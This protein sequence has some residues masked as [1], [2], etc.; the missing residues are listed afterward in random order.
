MKKVHFTLQG[1]GGVG[2]SYASSCTTQF[3]NENGEPVISMD[4]DPVNATLSGYPSLNAVRVELMEGSNLNQRQFD[5]MMETILEEDSNFVIDNGASS[6]IPLSNYL[7]ENSAIE[8]ISAAGKQVV[9]HTVITGGQAML[10]TLHGFTGL[11]KQMPENAQIVVWLNEFFGHIEADGK[12]FE[13]MK[14][15]QAHKDRVTGII[16]LN[17]QTSD[18][19]GKDVELMLDRKMTFADVAAGSDFGLMSKQRLAMVKR[20]IFDQLANVI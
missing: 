13:E 14:A 3:Y 9:I 10:D 7:L 19:F 20:S 18:T 15:Y 8:L 4:T 12:Q 6:F 11:A 1:K 2:K 5:S 17:R 16:R